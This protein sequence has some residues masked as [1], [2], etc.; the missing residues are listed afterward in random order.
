MSGYGGRG[1]QGVT[2]EPS[3]FLQ[4]FEKD[5]GWYTFGGIQL[6]ELWIN[7]RVEPTSQQFE[8][9][10]L[11][12]H[13]G[14]EQVIRIDFEELQ[15]LNDWTLE[16]WAVRHRR[17]MRKQQEGGGYHMVPRKVCVMRLKNDLLQAQIA[18]AAR[19]KR[20]RQQAEVEAR[21]A[22]A[23]EERRVV[24][25]EHLSRFIGRS[26]TGVEVS[27]DFLSVKLDDGTELTVGLGGGDP[28]DAWPIVDNYSLRDYTPDTYE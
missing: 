19:T 12:I 18:E 20:E 6:K 1:R 11:V 10:T 24:L 23:L 7:D 26:I 4:R 28:Y 15:V 16:V 13:Y 22:V 9:T 27:R 8:G 3:E 21:K 2:I 5:S 14:V 25:E 17:E